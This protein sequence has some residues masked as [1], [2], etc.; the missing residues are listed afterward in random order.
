MTRTGTWA[1]H[2]L[3]VI[4]LCKQPVSPKGSDCF[5]LASDFL[6]G[7]AFSEEK[8]QKGTK[9]SWRKKQQIV[10]SECTLVTDL[11]KTTVQNHQIS[12]NFVR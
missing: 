3:W 9:R 6:F 1:P 5:L 2:M 12:Y 4:A 7:H 11:S 8:W 10:V